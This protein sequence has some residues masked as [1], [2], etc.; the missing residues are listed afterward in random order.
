MKF[1]DLIY[2][3]FQNFRNRKS[4][5]F[6]TILGVAVA[7]AV[8]LALVS[9]GYG[10][11]RNLLNQI[12]TQEALQTLDILPSDSTVIALNQATVANISRLPNVE[13]VSPEATIDGQASLGGTISETSLDIVDSSYFGLDGK[14]PLLGR[15]Q[16]ENDVDKIVISQTVASLFNLASSSAIGKI[17]QLVAY[18]PDAKNPSVT[19]DV[20]LGSNFEVVGVV[21]DSSESGDIYILNTDV[22]NFPITSYQSAEVQVNSTANMDT[23]RTALINQGFI[24]SSLSDTVR[25]A[26]QIFEI[27]QIALGT[28]GIFAL[29]VAAIG[30][31]NTMTISL[32][33]RTNEIGIMRAIGATPGDIKKIFLGESVII[34]FLGGLFGIFL[35]IVGSQILNWLFDLLASALGGHGTSLFSYPLWFMLFIICISTFVGLAGGVWPAYRAGTLNPLQALRYK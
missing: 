28:F 29:I 2:I 23:V 30:L 15:F 12:T 35:G 34:G 6:F 4:R 11:Q 18:V 14:S 31:V 10:L 5:V 8:V 26:N 25:Q 22:P 21:S 24:V 20:Q 13:A 27:M 33:E 16:T 9:F 7:I 17:M 32:L 1:S 19:D 3:S